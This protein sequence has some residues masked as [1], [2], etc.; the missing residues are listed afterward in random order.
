MN[1]PRRSR[2]FRPAS[3]ELEPRLQLSAL[4]GTGLGPPPIPIGAVNTSGPA[5]ADIAVT[6]LTV[7]NLANN[8]FRLTATLVNEGFATTGNAP[9]AN[10]AVKPGGTLPPPTQTGPAYPGGGVFEIT[11]TSGGTVLNSQPTGPVLSTPVTPQ[12]LVSMPIPALASGQSI[13]L[14]TVAHGRAIFT[15]SA[16][17]S[18]GA[19]GL[20]VPLPDANPADNSQTVDNL[21]QHTVT[22]NTSNLGLLPVIGAAV[23]NAQVRLD[24]NHGMISIPGVLNTSFTIPGQTVSYDLGVTTVSATYYLNN[25]VSTGASLSY[26]NGGLAVTVSFANNADALHTSSSLFPDL[27]VKNLKVKIDLP[28]SYNAQYQYFQVGNASVTVTGD[29]SANGLLGPL[30]NLLLPDI[31]QKISDKISGLIDA[32]LDTISY[33]ITKPIHDFLAGGR[34]VSAV[35]QPDQMTVTVE[36]PS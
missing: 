26:E 7:Q 4:P 21:V 18:L 29:W 11:S 5:V 36:T 28:L 16:V 14:S 24:A 15:A 8:Q 23:Q 32:H 30:F 10:I 9:G 34:I 20:P 22:L 1:P 19:N 6:G 17:P 25:L 33:E 12:V 13:Q 27:S 31:N 2:S 3:D 35:I